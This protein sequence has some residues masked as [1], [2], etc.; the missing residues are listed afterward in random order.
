M[1]VEGELI[2]DVTGDD[3]AILI[4]RHGRTLD[5][6]QII[7]SSYMSSL[8]KFHYPI[9]IDIEGYKL[10]RKAKL[11]AIAYAAAAHAKQLHSRSSLPAMNAYERRI[12]HM[13][14][15]NDPAVSTYSEG[16]EPERHVI[17]TYVR[18]K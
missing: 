11:Q 1:M 15:I 8:L 5:A 13:A 6:L 16:E 17:V 18:N 7:L 10:R 14:L 9:I 3:F 4:G 12:V 2:I